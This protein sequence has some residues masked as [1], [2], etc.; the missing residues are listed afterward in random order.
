VAV[1]GQASA[2]LT[3]NASAQ[4]GELALPR[5][6]APV[7]WPGVAGA[8]VFGMLFARRFRKNAPWRP[9]LLSLC[10][11]ASL[12]AVSCSSGSVPINNLST[13]PPPPK[14]AAVGYSVVVTAT[15]NGIAHNATIDVVV[16]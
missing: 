9:L 15:S 5:R 16:P 14:P 1:N 10:V 2:T 7:R 8:L 3:V 6:N 4:A 11:L 12:C 13:P